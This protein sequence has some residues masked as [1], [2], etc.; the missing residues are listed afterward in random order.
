MKLKKQREGAGV[1]KYE[2]ERQKRRTRGTGR[3]YRQ[4]ESEFQRREWL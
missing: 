4:A 2:E 3:K 1:T